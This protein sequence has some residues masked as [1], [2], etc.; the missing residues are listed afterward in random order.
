L[1]Y[2]PSYLAYV[3][4]PSY[5]AFNHYG[6]LVINW[7][8]NRLT[9]SLVQSSTV[10]SMVVRD[11]ANHATQISFNTTLNATYEVG[12]RTTLQASIG[13]SLL[14]YTQSQYY[15]SAQWTE[16]LWADY[17]WRD[18]VSTGVGVSVSE[19]QVQ[20]QPTQFGVAPQARAS[21][22]PMPKLTL[23]GSVGFQFLDYGTG[24]STVG[25]PI[26]SLTLRYQF[27]PE[28]YV[29]LEAHRTQQS[30]S[31]L[32]AQNYVETGFSVSFT[33]RLFQRFNVILEGGYSNDQYQSTQT[34][35]NTGRDDSYYFARAAA[36]MLI[37][38]RWGTG[39]FYERRSNTS[40]TLYSY[41]EN[42]IGVRGSWGF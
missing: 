39:I 33:R 30:S 17:H 23:Q 20:D 21:W 15:G 9:L 36:D 14:D 24:A 2:R 38:R 6:D 27:Y 32:Y 1:T 19:T 28:S 10:S 42:M 11:L 25:N 34:G 41:D 22:V 18:N 3:N 31:L 40:S 13:Y 7:P 26:M 5:N 4:N 35:L 8:M 12:A 37:G 16:Q 29:N